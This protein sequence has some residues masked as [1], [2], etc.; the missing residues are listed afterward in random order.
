M[1]PIISRT[2]FG[3]RP[4][5]YVRQFIYALIP[6]AIIFNFMLSKKGEFGI[7]WPMYALM[8]ANVVLY[9]YARHF[10]SSVFGLLRGDGTYYVS[11]VVLLLWNLLVLAIVLGIAVFVAP[12]GLI[13]LYFQN[14]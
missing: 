5:Y 10:V 6:T 8:I 12:L 4:A 1:H 7:L 9:P 14:K 3:L 11:V 2:F 13:V